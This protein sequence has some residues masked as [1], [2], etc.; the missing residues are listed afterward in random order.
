MQLTQ[1]VGTLDRIARL[2]LGAVLGVVFLAGIVAAPLSYLVGAL[3]VIMFATSALGF[4][5]IYRIVGVR[6]CPI[7]RV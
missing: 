4:C 2:G 3:S 5:P 1:N 6:T 7:Q